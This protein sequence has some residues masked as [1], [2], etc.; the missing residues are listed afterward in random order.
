MI[1]QLLTRRQ[2]AELL[3]VS[4][5]HVSTLVATEKLPAL[6]LGR[7]GG[8]VMLRFREQ[9]VVEW[10]EGRRERQITATLEGRRYNRRESA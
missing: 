9:E 10:L 8:R 6:K 1:D 7:D 5:P 4:A 2:V 3:S